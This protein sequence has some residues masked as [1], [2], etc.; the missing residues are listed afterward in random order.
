ML[1]TILWDHDGVLV[2]TERL[3]YRAT[4]E[5]LARFGVDLAVE[6]YRQFHLVEARGSWHLLKGVTPDEVEVLRRERNDLY[7]KMLLANDV[8]V[9][10]VVPLLRR[11]A[12][13]YRMAVVT[14][15]NREHFEAIHRRTGLPELMQFVL[16]RED[17]GECKPHP[18][19]Y[20]R[21]VERFGA[22]TEDCVVV[23]DSTRGLTAAKAA[24]LRC[25]IVHS[26]ITEGL[27]FEGAD[28]H[29]ASLAEVGDALLCLNSQGA[30]GRTL[31]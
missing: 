10:G 25:W 23:E 11:L 16:A 30:S 18:E 3:Y 14:S 19:P 24:G 8:L 7:L 1:N 26:E 27:D 17:Y 9:P 15:S 31:E 21:A 28:R 4:R 12:E 22:A 5:V 13:R 2:D 29:C 20:L 6:Q